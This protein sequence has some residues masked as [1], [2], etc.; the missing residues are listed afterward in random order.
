[1]QAVNRPSVCACSHPG[2]DRPFWHTGRRCDVV[3]RV[4]RARRSK[5]LI[6]LLKDAGVDMTTDGPLDLTIKQMN[7]V[8]DEM[9]KL[10]AKR[11]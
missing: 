1:M 6:D 5:Y 7:R 4:L 11:R 2:H 9:D 8:M 10:L 3:H